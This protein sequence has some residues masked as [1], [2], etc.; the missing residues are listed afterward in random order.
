MFRFLVL[1]AI[2]CHDIQ[3]HSKVKEQFEELV[4][5]F[6]KRLSKNDII[7]DVVCGKGPYCGTN[8]VGTD[9]TP[10]IMRGV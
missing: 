5:S 1:R 10:R 3:C 6:L 2:H 7:G 4:F 8:I 9:Q